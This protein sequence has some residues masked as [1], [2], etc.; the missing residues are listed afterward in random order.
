VFVSKNGPRYSRE[1]AAAAI[2]A[3]LS[4]SEAL[5]KLGMRAAGGNHATLKKYVVEWGISTAH[6]DPAAQ[7]KAHLQAL[8]GERRRPLSE[9]L[10]ANSGYS[11]GSLKR[12][13][14]EEGLKQRRCELCGQDEN[15]CGK[16]MA[17][18]LDHVN[19]VATDN[20]LENLQIVCPNC[21]ATLDTHCGRNKPCVCPTCRTTYRP[22][23][24]AQRFCS[25]DCFA[26]SNVGVAKP[27]RRKVISTGHRER[28]VER[29]SYRQLLAE[30]E[31]TN[32]CAVGRRYGVS[33]NAIRKWVRQYE[34]ELE[35]R[36]G[37]AVLFRSA[38]A[39]GFRARLEC[40]AVRGHYAQHPHCLQPEPQAF[41]AV[42]G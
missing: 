28:R 36:S 19:G 30:I 3:S 34:R 37:L 20:R 40:R 18:I 17:L 24:S 2:A 8:A 41:S 4:F 35:V 39:A 7:R 1:Q 12:R 42:G 38:H 14:Y 22:R 25:H 9:I 31:S 21:A 26:R 33:D 15:W 10:V 16:R 6:F 32:Y 11:R 23:R 29:P 13:L 27:S 5:R